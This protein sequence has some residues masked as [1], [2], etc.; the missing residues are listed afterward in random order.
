MQQIHELPLAEDDR[1]VFV[2]DYVDRG[3]EVALTLDLLI[4]LRDQR[5]NTIF[6]RGNHDQSMMDVRDLLDPG[7]ETELR[8]DDVSWW[9]QY[10]GRQTMASYGGEN[11]WYRQVPPT[12]WQFLETTGMEHR[13]SGYIFVHAGLL[14][15]GMRWF[16]AADPRLWIREA[17]LESDDDFGGTVVFG[18]T[19]TRDGEPLVQPNKIGIDTGA[20]YGGPLTAALLEPDHIV[21]F[22]RA[23]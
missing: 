9:F 8:F 5:P 17:F 23:D 3:P 20:A 22:L 11:D 18:H 21:R 19:P 15:K 10:G 1:I 12:H 14:P 16:D 2:G 7:R 4:Q 13:E 6:L